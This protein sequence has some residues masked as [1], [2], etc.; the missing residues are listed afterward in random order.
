MSQKQSAAGRGGGNLGALQV[1]GKGPRKSIGGKA[2]RA[3]TAGMAKGGRPRQKG[4]VQREYD[5]LCVDLQASRGGVP[6]APN[7]FLTA[8]LL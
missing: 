6:M 5:R 1:G 7:C 3:S 2:P 8:C 4:V